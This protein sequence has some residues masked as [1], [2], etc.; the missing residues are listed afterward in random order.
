MENTM[1]FDLIDQCLL[2]KVYD[3][4]EQEDACGYG[5]YLLE[6]E[7]KL[8]ADLTEEQRERVRKLEYAVIRKYEHLYYE[9]QIYLT[10]YAFRLGMDVQHAIDEEEMH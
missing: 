6:E 3:K 4:A 7:D 8:F 5:Q 9:V 10:N 2:Q 1:L